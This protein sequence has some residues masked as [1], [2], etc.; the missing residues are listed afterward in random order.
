MTIFLKERFDDCE[1]ENAKAALIKFV[2]NIKVVYPGRHSYIF[3]THLLLHM[4]KAVEILDVL[5]VSF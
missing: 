5:Y 4:P 3:N 1:F 2:D